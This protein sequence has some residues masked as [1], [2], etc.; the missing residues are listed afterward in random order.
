MITPNEVSAIS[1]IVDNDQVRVVLYHNGR[2]VH[3]PL[4]AVLKA[5]QEQVEDL[6]TR[7][8]ELETP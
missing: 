8:T 3:V 6:D 2:L 5:I 7:V 4:N 1:D